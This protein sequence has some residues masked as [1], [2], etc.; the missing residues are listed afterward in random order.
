MRRR[1]KSFQELIK[2]DIKQEYAENPPIQNEAM[3]EWDTGK[4]MSATEAKI[5]SDHTDALMQ[6]KMKALQERMERIL[7]FGEA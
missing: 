1:A 4:Y 7:W 2:E 6:K 5:T 3:E